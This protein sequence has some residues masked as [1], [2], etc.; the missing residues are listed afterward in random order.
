MRMLV[1]AFAVTLSAVVPARAQLTGPYAPAPAQVNGAARTAD[2]RARQATNDYAVCLVKREHRGV[3]RA[4]AMPAGAASYRAL[5]RL[6]DGE[7]LYNAELRMP[8]VILR[9]AAFRALYLRSFA[10]R[11]GKAAVK[12][13][14]IADAGSDQQALLHAGLL[15]YGS[16]IA[17]ANPAASRA[18]VIA[19]AGMPAE[20]A[21][22]DALR[23]DLADCLPGGMT[24]KL[25]KAV[26]QGMMAEVLYRETAG[27][28]PIA[29]DKN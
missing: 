29:Q 1:L 14:Y 7:C 17:R 20:S 2:V 13:D 19:T 9:G 4:L 23:K 8:N 27:M 15:A 6:A 16:C 12:I 26:L 10:R 21:A 22:I 28:M 5:G 25:G 24:T 18:L 3:E 11:P